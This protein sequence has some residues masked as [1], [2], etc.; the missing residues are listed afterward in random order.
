MR[1]TGA[2]RPF[3]SVVGGLLALT[4]GVLVRAFCGRY[5]DVERRKYL[6]V[7]AVDVGAVRLVVVPGLTV[8]LIFLFG[9]ELRVCRSYRELT[10]SL[11][12]ACLCVRTLFGDFYFPLHVGHVVLERVEVCLLSPAV[13]AGGCRSILWLFHGDRDSYQRGDMCAAGFIARFPAELGC[14]V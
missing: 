14:V 9:V 8:S 10:E 3:V 11:P 7:V 5:D 12:S 4:R 1:R 6:V 13:E 2:N